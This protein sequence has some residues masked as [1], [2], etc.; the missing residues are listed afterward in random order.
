[1]AVLWLEVDEC[2]VKRAKNY[3]CKLGSCLAQMKIKH[4]RMSNLYSHLKMHHPSECLAV[5]PASIEGKGKGSSQQGTIEE[6]LSILPNFTLIHMSR[7]RL[8]RASHTT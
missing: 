8:Q 4:A 1:M 6:F 2:R 7:D 5:R 3:L